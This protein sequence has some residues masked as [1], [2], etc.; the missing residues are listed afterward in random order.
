MAEFHKILDQISGT[1]KT[2]QDVGNQIVE[3]YPQSKNLV[4]LASDL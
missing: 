3:R 2:L 1:Q 4:D